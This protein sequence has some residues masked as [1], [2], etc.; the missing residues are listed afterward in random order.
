MT[1]KTRTGKESHCAIMTTETEKTALCDRELNIT[2]LR[3][4]E[5]RMRGETKTKTEGDFTK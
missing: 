4:K 2:A 3:R 1:A 5:M